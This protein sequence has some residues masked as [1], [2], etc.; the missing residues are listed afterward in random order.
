MLANA[1]VINHQLSMTNSYIEL[2]S[3]VYMKSV[4]LLGVKIVREDKVC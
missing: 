3:N 4:S 2:S 1:M